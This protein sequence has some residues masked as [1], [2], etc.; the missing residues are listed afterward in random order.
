MRDAPTWRIL[1]DEAENIGQIPNLEKLMATIRSRNAIKLSIQTQRQR[2][3]LQ[4][5]QL[6]GGVFFLAQEKSILFPRC[7]SVILVVIF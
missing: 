1:I 2:P 5:L 3:Q 4:F 6:G 7:S